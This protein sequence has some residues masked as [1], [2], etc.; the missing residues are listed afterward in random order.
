MTIRERSTHASSPNQKWLTLLPVAI[1]LLVIAAIAVAAIVGDLPVLE[2]GTTNLAVIFL[3][4]LVSGGLGCLAMQGGLLTMAV[5]QSTPAPSS[6]LA[7]PPTLKGQAGPIALFLAAKLLAYTA[8]G[9]G[10]GLVGSVIGIAPIWQGWLQIAIGAY[11]LGVAGQLLNLHPVFRRF[12]VQPPRA[13]QVWLRREAKSGQSLAPALLGALTILVPCGTTQAMLVVAI[14][15]GSALG[16]A[17]VLFAFVLGT[18]PLFFALGFLAARL[19]AAMQHLFT[20]VAAVAVAVMALL[21]IHAGLALA[22]VPDLDVVLGRPPSGDIGSPV[23]AADAANPETDTAVQS[24]TIQANPTFYLPPRVQLQVGTPARVRVQTGRMI[25]CTSTFTI[26][27]LGVRR[28]IPPNSAV[29]IDIPTDQA[30][31]IPF[32]CG[33]GM[34]RGVIEVIP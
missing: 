5:T 4:G 3:T 25:G 9:A 8:L 28:Y 21:S 19:G 29:L 7:S 18:S 14:G 30:R 11:M 23:L 15:T 17:L 32:V 13:V 12:S 26:P 1:A 10:L 16:G 20:R 6:V 2:S 22:G 34:Y 33:M 24:V 27:S 31:T